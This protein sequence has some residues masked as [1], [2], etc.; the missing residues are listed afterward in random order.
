MGGFISNPPP[1]TKLTALQR[2]FRMLQLDRKDISYVY[3][4]AIFS[5]LITLTLPLGIQAIIG[6]IAG[7]AISA[8]L[9]L[10]IVM[11]TLGTMLTGI[12]KVMQLTVTE[13]IQR[14]LFT[15][16]SFEFAWRLPRIKFEKLLGDYPPELVNRFFDTLTLQ[17]GLPKLL[18]DVS[19]A[20]L[21]IIFGLLLISFYHATFVVFSITLIVLL[22]AIFYFTGGRGLSTSM[23]E[24]KYKY[25]VAHWLEEIGRAVTTFKLS[26]QSKLPMKKTEAL[27]DGYLAHRHA[28]FRILLWQYGAMVVFE[29]L[30]TLTLLA[31]GSMLVIDNAITIGQFVAAEIIIILILGSIEKLILSID[32]IYD[33][34]T[35]VEKIGYV[36]DLELETGEEGICFDQIDRPG[37]G[38]EVV[39]RNLT[40]KFPD[41]DR[42]V[43]NNLNLE[44][45]GGEKICILGPNR[46][47]KSTLIQL[48]GM[49][50]TKYEGS[51]SFN[52]IPA[53]NL[54][55]QDLRRHIGDYM[56]DEDLFRATL[57]ENLWLH[58][59]EP[60]L[61]Q[62]QDVMAQ[63]GL[64]S[65]V[66]Q[67]P[68]GYQ[69][70]L[71]PSG[72][73]LPASVRTKLLLARTLMGN[74][75]LL[76]LGDFG[77]S[78]NAADRRR[79]TDV[80]THA[81]NT[82]TILAVSDDAYF[83]SRCDR[84]I[85]LGDGEL[86]LSGSYDQMIKDKRVALALGLVSDSTTL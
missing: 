70:E 33:M 26:G 27:V 55:Y 10:L 50:Y 60:D 37:Q 22:V 45:K 35:A 49:L 12:L 86:L 71:M 8:A 59:E 67:L 43:I 21:Q 58:D 46:S 48:A 40:F 1:M 56:R 83:A 24:S 75:R 74:P 36:T 39:F 64:T 63:I 41:N 11:V 14:R 5:G 68:D 38:L 16:S 54:N 51:I 81:D 85:F 23:M 77:A 6:M 18:T 42:N 34:L 62:V 28:H 82:C 19:T 65:Y 44:V 61:Q 4:Y 78:L 80:L 7:G 15:R 29:T 47:G 32:T 57:L 84:V 17:K 20:A 52:G 79:V 3:L 9:I 72:R 76:A 31:I 30:I 53:R 13:S 66:A 25:K 69:T 73:N 2:F